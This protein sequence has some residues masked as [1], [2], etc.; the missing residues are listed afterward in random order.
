MPHKRGAVPNMGDTTPATRV[1]LATLGRTGRRAGGTRRG[2]RRAARAKKRSTRKRSKS[3]TGGRK[4]L[5]KGSPAAKA[6]GRKMRA[7][8]KRK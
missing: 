6:W 3:S 4:R 5:T 1:H 8:R 7:L 2:K